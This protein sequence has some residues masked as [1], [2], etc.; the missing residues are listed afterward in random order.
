MGWTAVNDEKNLVLGADHQ[1]PEKL[2]ENIGIDAAFFLD[3]ESHMAARSHRRD[4][5][6]AV[7]R[8]STQHDWSLALL[9]PGATGMVI[10]AHMRCVSK[11]DIGLFSMRQSFDLRVFL[12]EPLL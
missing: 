5:T 10:R 1:A 3:R 11:I 2:D 9:A 12:L 6:H 8:P 7:P 4:Q